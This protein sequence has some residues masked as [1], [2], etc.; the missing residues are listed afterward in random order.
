MGLPGGAQEACLLCPPLTLSTCM[1]LDKLSKPFAPVQVKQSG[2]DVLK[3]EALSF[4]IF[5]TTSITQR[6]PGQSNILNN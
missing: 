6:N 3:L 4:Q 1:I 2:L 5:P